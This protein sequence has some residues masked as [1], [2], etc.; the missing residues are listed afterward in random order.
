MIIIQNILRMAIHGRARCVRYKH[1]QHFSCWFRLVSSVV[2]MWAGVERTRSSKWIHFFSLRKM[3][4]ANRK[5]EWSDIDGALPKPE[6]FH[7]GKDDADSLYHCRIQLCE[8]EGFQSHIKNKHS[9]MV[10]LSRRKPPCRLKACP[11]LFQ[12]ANEI[13]RLKYRWWFIVY[14]LKTRCKINAFILT[15]QQNWR[16][17]Y[18]LADWKCSGYKEVV[19]NNRFRINFSLSFA[20]KRR[21]RRRNYVSK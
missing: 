2:V 13:V 3:S 6:R 9:W 4:K 5:I 12:S 1:A 19:P 16:A 17:I 15:F 20:S 14:A 7:L 21:R 18:N 11:K 8:H 10:L